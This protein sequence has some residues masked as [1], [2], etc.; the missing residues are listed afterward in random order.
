[1]GRFRRTG[2]RRR[3]NVELA[4]VQEDRFY[5]QEDFEPEIIAKH[6][7]KI[8]HEEE[9]AEYMASTLCIKMPIWDGTQKTVVCINLHYCR[10]DEEKFWCAMCYL[11]YR[12]SGSKFNDSINCILDYGDKLGHQVEITKILLAIGVDV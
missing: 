8:Y 2:I 4:P 12:G 6:L 9:Y 3:P 7:I 5:Q 1:M 10:T 11:K